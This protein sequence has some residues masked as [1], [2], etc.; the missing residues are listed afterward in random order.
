MSEMA[1]NNDQTTMEDNNNGNNSMEISQD[2]TAAV[3]SSASL[4]YQ[5]SIPLAQGQRSWADHVSNAEQ[6]VR[7][8]AQPEPA[9]SSQLLGPS[10]YRARRTATGE[11]TKF[12]KQT[13]VIPDHGYN[14]KEII[15][16]FVK[17]VGLLAKIIFKS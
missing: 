6:Q 11:S 12:V 8:T 4:P 15:E 3:P 5:P 9:A 2:S 1:C 10:I 14:Y 13:V 17:E 7:A 16:S